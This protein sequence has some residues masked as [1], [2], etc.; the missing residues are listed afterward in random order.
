MGESVKLTPEQLAE[1]RA[2]AHGEMRS[3]TGSP[4]YNRG[5]LLLELIAEVE[6]WREVHAEYGPTEREVSNAQ[7]ADLR[8]DVR[9][10]E[11]REQMALN[12][13]DQ[14]RRE[15]REACA[16]LAE[17]SFP[18]SMGPIERARCD[19]AMEIADAIR[20]RGGSDE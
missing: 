19:H 20:A 11:D 13:I 18:Y 16:K 4:L 15:E 17:G 12:A 10:A 5:R 2:R 7:V 14:A 9:A 3:I 6:C 1:L 8:E